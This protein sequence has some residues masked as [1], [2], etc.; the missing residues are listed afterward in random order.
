MEGTLRSGGTGNVGTG[1]ETFGLINSERLSYSSAPS[2]FRKL[3]LSFRIQALMGSWSQPY[4]LG[5]VYQSSL[6]CKDCAIG[7]GRCLNSKL[8]NGDF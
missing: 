6:E 4:D 3:F 2:N 5:L 8:G 7:E 1:H